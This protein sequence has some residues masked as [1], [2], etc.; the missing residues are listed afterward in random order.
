MIST[1]H[2]NYSGDQ[3]KMNEMGEACGT[4]DGTEVVHTQFWWEDVREREGLE[5][6]VVDGRITN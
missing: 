6:L 2:Q 3:I 5:D 4:F 1:L